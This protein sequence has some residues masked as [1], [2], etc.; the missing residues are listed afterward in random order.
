MWVYRNI[1]IFIGVYIA[2]PFDP[3]HFQILATSQD[4][5]KTGRAARGTD[6]AF[7]W[8]RSLK[9]QARGAGTAVPQQNGQRKWRIPAPSFKNRPEMM[10]NHGEASEADSQLRTW[11]WTPTPKSQE[12]PVVGM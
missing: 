11:T 2:V 5:T 4:L 8:C 6:Q 12:M 1:Y 9:C 10:Q 7:D 3:R